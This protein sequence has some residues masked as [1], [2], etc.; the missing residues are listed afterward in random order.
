MSADGKIL[1]PLALV[2]GG[3]AI[4]VT[5]SD[6]A[7]YAGRI[8]GSDDATQLAVVSIG[9]ERQH[10]FC[11]TR[12]GK[13][14]RGRRRATWLASN[15]PAP[16]LVSKDQSV[17]PFGSVSSFGA[18]ASDSTG[19]QLLDTLR[20]QARDLAAIPRS[21]PSS[22]T[23]QPRSSASSPSARAT[24]SSRCRSFG[25][26]GRPADRRSW[27]CGSWMARDRGRSRRRRHSADGGD[28]RWRRQPCGRLPF[29][30]AS[31]SSKSTEADCSGARRVAAPETSS[32]PSTV[33]E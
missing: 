29:R 4:A 24:A 27:A 26:G 31:R 7:V 20:L 1:V 9:V 6:G 14:H 5:T 16:R 30:R 10:G 11:A 22:S 12:G 28:R 32:K 8:V 25:R 13:R 2:L 21:G 3:M 19:Y 18:A 33:A 15:G 17:L 23:T